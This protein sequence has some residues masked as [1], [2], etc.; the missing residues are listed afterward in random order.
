MKWKIT[1]TVEKETG[2]ARS[3]GVYSGKRL[4]GTK[5]ENNELISYSVIN[6][7]I[8]QRRQNNRL[9]ELWET[10]NAFNV[11]LHYMHCEKKKINAE[12]RRILIQ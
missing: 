5:K 11:F 1:H 4:Q 7:N 8:R 9:A 10:E 3:W 12:D 2:K 6:Q